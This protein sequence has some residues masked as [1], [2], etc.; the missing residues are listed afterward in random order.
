MTNWGSRLTALAQMDSDQP[1]A[2]LATLLKWCGAAVRADNS[3]RCVVSGRR[4]QR[5]ASGDLANPTAAPGVTFNKEHR[6]RS[7]R[8][9]TSKPTGRMAPCGR[10]LSGLISHRQR[11]GETRAPS[12]SS[13]TL[14]GCMVAWTGGIPTAPDVDRRVAVST[15]TPRPESSPHPPGV[16]PA[17]ADHARP[18]LPNGGSVGI[19]VRKCRSD[20]D[21]GDI[22]IMLGA[23]RRIGLSRDHARPDQ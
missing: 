9:L 23:T 11:V 20:W 10:M 8:R 19:G 12:A 4:S 13:A 14:G 22:T 6:P 2:S 3:E 5:A 16:N 17:R 21:V 1:A 7:G 15:S 18:L